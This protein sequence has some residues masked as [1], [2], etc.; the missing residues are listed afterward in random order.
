[1]ETFEA[2]LLTDAVANIYVDL[3]LVGFILDEK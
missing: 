3:K 2:V 1:M